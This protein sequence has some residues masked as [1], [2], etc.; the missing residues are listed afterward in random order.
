MGY[1]FYEIYI[2]AQRAFRAMGFPFGADEDAGF[3]IAWLELNHFNGIEILHKLLKSINQQY[4]GVIEFE[5][6]NT[7]IDFKNSTV[8]MKGSGLVD[9]L[10][11]ISNQKEKVLA[12]IKNCPDAILFL[13]LLYKISKKNNYIELNFSNSKNKVSKYKIKNK[14]IY[15]ESLANQNLLINNEVRI[16]INHNHDNLKNDSKQKIITQKIIQNNL[17]HS[18]LAKE[19]LWKEISQIANK[20]F[21]PESEESRN[22]GA[23]GGDAND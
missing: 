19:N 6:L 18:I 3:I 14:E 12:N 1:S 5:N 23:G 2:T 8:L 13:P 15:F 11:S 4:N 16:T 10:Q 7:S 22:K 9:Y 21:V 20:T 17:A